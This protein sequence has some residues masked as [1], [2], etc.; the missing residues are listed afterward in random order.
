[1]RPDRP[2]KMESGS[3]IAK[4][5]PRSL[6][7]QL[8]AAQHDPKMAPRLPQMAQERRHRGPRWGRDGPKI[9]QTGPKMAPNWFQVGEHEVKMGKI[10]PKRPEGKQIQNLE[11]IIVFMGSEAYRKAPESPT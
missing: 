11:K 9:A 8:A 10:R 6:A 2:I 5:G 3:E 1:M 7:D 4:N